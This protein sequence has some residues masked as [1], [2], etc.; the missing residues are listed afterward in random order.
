MPFYRKEDGSMRMVYV[1][2]HKH[3]CILWPFFNFNLNLLIVGSPFQSNE[4]NHKSTFL[5]ILFIIL[6]KFLYLE[7]ILKW[8][9]HAYTCVH[10]HA[11]ACVCARACARVRAQPKIIFDQKNFFWPK[12]FFHHKK[13]MFFTKK[14]FFHQNIFFYTKLFFTKK[15]QKKNINCAITLI[16]P[17]HQPHRRATFP[18]GP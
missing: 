8:S 13:K 17:K 7:L 10:V 5:K 3:I 4:G 1:Y 11:H 12:F 15:K 14:N 9:L 18:E 2:F 6:F 16:S